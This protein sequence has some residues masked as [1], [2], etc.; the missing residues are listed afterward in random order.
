MP[1]AETTGRYTFDNDIPAAA[2]QLDHLAELLDPHS[3]RVLANTGVGPGWRCFDIGSGAGTIATWLAGRVGADGY[4]VAGD[5]K[6]HHVPAH[7][8]IEVRRFDV[9]TDEVPAHAFD[10]I[11]ARLVL[12][13]LPERERVLHR[14]A[15]ALA[16]GGYLVIS[17]FHW[18]TASD[19]VLHAPNSGDE[20]LFDL[21]N[22]TLADIAVR[23]GADLTWAR[24][25]HATMRA[26]GLAEVYTEID[27][28]SWAGGQSGC[29]L[30]RANSFQLE[31]QLRRAGMSH[32]QLEQVRA[33]LLHPD[34]VRLSPLLL[35]S[36]GRK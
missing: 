27:V 24:R 31:G 17:D 10:V 35:T 25:I 18:S 12:M 20:A 28:Q 11:H 5:L 32:G 13:H 21:F 8:G 3:Q 6:P 7:H 16:P 4:V 1:T 26:A 33:L 2:E 14:L 30:D 23:N 29:L 9:R 19:L 15:Q 34:F 36:V 22:R